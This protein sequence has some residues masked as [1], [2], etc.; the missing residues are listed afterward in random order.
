M[1]K[2][3]KKN[4]GKNK[5][6]RPKA[7]NIHGHYY[8]F[9]CMGIAFSAVCLRTHICSLICTITKDTHTS[10]GICLNIKSSSIELS[11]S[12]NSLGY[13]LL[14]KSGRSNLKPHSHIFIQKKK[15]HIHT[16]NCQFRETLS[17]L[18]DIVESWSSTN[19]LVSSS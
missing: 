15:N 12:N 7:T 2:N 16:C 14:W 11:Q 1:K 19:I 13:K 8:V 3:T 6:S 10:S 18:V 5:K 4:I 17:E 9:M